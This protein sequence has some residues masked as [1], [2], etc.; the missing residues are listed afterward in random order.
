MKKYLH[1]TVWLSGSSTF[2]HPI[3]IYYGD[4]SRENGSSI[5]FQ[6]DSDKRIFDKF[7][8]RTVEKYSDF[9][10]SG[11]FVPNDGSCPAEIVFRFKGVTQ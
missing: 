5:V 2:V 9:I 1:K 11:F 4:L 8:D 10:T 7:I 6:W 3:S